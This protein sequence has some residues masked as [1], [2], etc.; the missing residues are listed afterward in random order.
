MKFGN[1]PTESVVF[2]RPSPPTGCDLRDLWAD[3]AT[4]TVKICTGHNPDVWEA[5]GGGGGATAW[6]E[7][8]GKPATF[9]P[10]AHN[11]DT[12]YYTEA[13]VDGFLAGKSA[14]THTHAQ[15][16]DRQ[17]S[18]TAATDHTFP[19]GADADKYLA[20]DGTFK[21]LP[22]GG[23]GE[24]FPVG[25]IFISVVATSPTVLLGYGVWTAFGAG[26]A[27]VGI[28]PLQTEFD[29]VK[30]TGGAKTH[31]LTEAEMPSH[32]HVQG[33]NSATTGGLSGYTPDTSTNTR[34]NSGY[35]TSATGGG[36]AH[37]NLQPYIVA[38]FWER[39]A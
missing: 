4:N 20:G 12:V 31:T 36:G 30:E 27:M 29:T 33:V 32:T 18:V 15:L 37:N 9:P 38:Y 16:H 21:A 10:D 25:S 6:D 39:T 19:G 13:E 28:D 3:E 8:T 17:H 35:A 22:A 26:R 11:H 23:G 14:T 2:K 1:R 34:V 24:A 7:I 5:I